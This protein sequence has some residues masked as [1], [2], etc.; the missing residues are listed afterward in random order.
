MKIEIANIYGEEVEVVNVS[1]S[2][3]FKGKNLIDDV[4]LIQGL[5]KFICKGL[6]PQSIGLGGYYSIPRITG[7]LDD[8]TAAAINQFQIT[9]SSALLRKYFDG[10]IDPAHYRHRAIRRHGGH[11][12]TIT[13]LHFLAS[14]AA[15]MLGLG[16]DGYIQALANL[17]SRLAY[18]IDMA[19]IA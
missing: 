12:M 2:V 17:N 3:G 9:Q 1:D 14:D 10:R 13:F 19:I 11:V 15:V 5:L 18:A 7:V 6:S 16:S 8:E 4:L